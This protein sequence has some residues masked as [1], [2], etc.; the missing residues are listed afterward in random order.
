MCVGWRG[1]CMAWN[2][3]QGNDIGSLILPWL[4]IVLQGVLTKVV[5]SVGSLIYYVLYVEDMLAV[6]SMIEVEELKVKFSK[7]LDMKDLG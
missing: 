4:H 3:M 1:L 5:S 7:D 2:N 6:K